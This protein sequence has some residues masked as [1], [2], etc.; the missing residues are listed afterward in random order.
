MAFQKVPRPSEGSHL[1]VH[2][3]PFHPIDEE[4]VE[5]LMQE[6]LAKQSHSNV[7]TR[8]EKKCVVPAG[9]PVGESRHELHSSEYVF[10]GNHVNQ[11]DQPDLQNL[12]PVLDMLRKELNT[13]ENNQWCGGIV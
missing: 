1:R 2:V 10:Q 6:G 9:P 12:Y 11:G 13:L 4:K 3:V 5:E 7:S 8:V